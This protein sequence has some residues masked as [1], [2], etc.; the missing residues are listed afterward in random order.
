MGDKGFAG[1]EDLRGLLAV[2]LGTD[3]A[4]RERSGYVNALRAAKTSDYGR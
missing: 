1:I 4:D 3:G 2:P